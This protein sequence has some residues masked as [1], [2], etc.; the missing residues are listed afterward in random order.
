MKT[1]IA[2]LTDG[3]AEASALWRWLGTRGIESILVELPRDADLAREAEARLEMHT[4]ERI[5]IL[6]R[7]AG[8]ETATLDAV[9]GWLGG[10]DPISIRTRGAN[11][12]E[13]RRTRGEP[14]ADAVDR[15][16]RALSP[17]TRRIAPR[18]RVGRPRGVF[19]YRGAGFD[20]CVTLLLNQD[21]RWT[22]RR[23]AAETGHVASGVHRIFV[24]LEQR[25]FLR[26]VRG[27]ATVRNPLGLRDELSE[28][29]ALRVGAPRQKAIPF[30]LTNRELVENCVFDLARRTHL[31]C[32]LAGPHGVAGPERFVGGP[33]TMYFDRD[34]TAELE[35]NGIERANRTGDLVAWIADEEGIYLHPREIG[36]YPATNRVVTYLDLVAAGTDRARLAADA[37]WAEK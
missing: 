16:L 2:V 9:S 15:L 29:W 19:P 11:V 3:S 8:S 18:G 5:L 22:E 14:G 4:P 7:T 28:A 10:L 31:R 23:M 35:A 17:G 6:S 26:R 37:V 25:G 21:D 34:P 1:R 13:E 30:R 36:G 24:E 12:I 32:L 27:A 33:V 20:V